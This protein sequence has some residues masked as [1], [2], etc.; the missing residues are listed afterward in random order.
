LDNIKV[1]W[2]D[3]AIKIYELISHIWKST[4]EQEEVF[5]KYRIAIN[6]YKNGQFNEALKQFIELSELNDKP[7]ITYKER[8]EYYIKNPPSDDWDWIWRM[9]S[10]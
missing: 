6:L 2:K 10:K 7:S 3:N 1:A 8:C 4:K 9:T 5:F